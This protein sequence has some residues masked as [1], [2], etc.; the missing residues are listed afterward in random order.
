M[1]SDTQ[2]YILDGGTIEILDWSIYDPAASPHSRRTLSV[3][4]Y[5]VVHD[6]RTLVWDTGLGDRLAGADPILVANHALF[7]VA[8]PLAKQ[9]RAAGHPADEIELL[10]L[11]HFHPDHV[12]N[13]DLFTRS[14]L[15]SQC[16]EYYAA[17]GPNARDHGYVPDDYAVIGDL[18][19]KLLDGDEDVFGDGA[20]V[21]KRLPGHTVGSQSLL[22]RLPERGSVLISGD[23][24]H[25]MENWENRV[26]PPV[27]NH[28]PEESARSLEAAA[29]LLREERAELWVQH[30][31]P[32]YLALR[33]ESRIFQ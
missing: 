29:A 17:F 33:A 7:T 15:V 25:T 8:E 18:P 22:V 1:S 4:V 27:L 10:A 21:I 6:G 31:H 19:T 24:V 12:G 2:I 9:L 11:S 32:Q 23:L 26:V 14:T 5:L 30:D 20:V 28:L 13:V 16:D 3:P